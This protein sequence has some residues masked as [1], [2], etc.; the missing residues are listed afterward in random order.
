MSSCSAAEKRDFWS[1]TRGHMC[2]RGFC[3]WLRAV[4]VSA[5]APPS[6]SGAQSA[7]LLFKVDWNSDLP[8]K[9]CDPLNKWDGSLRLDGGPDDRIVIDPDTE[10]DG[11]SRLRGA[12]ID[13]RQR[14]GKKQNN[15]ERNINGDA[16][17]FEQFNIS[18]SRIDE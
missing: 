16:G 5:C 17:K 7:R 13:G 10:T 3:V 18:A 12:A 14:A 4:N 2:A 9:L 15:L 8:L 11:G 6:A 1:V